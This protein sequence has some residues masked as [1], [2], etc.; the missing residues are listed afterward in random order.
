MAST[1]KKLTKTEIEMRWNA[2]IAFSKINS[3]IL[4]TASLS[5][6]VACVLAIGAL[7]ENLGDGV[8]IF[9]FLLF[10]FIVLFYRSLKTPEIIIDAY[11]TNLTR[12][13][14]EEISKTVRRREENTRLWLFSL[15]TFILCLPAI[16]IVTHSFLEFHGY[17][18]WCAW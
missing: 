6:L 11:A 13:E 5:S 15:W 9:S 17:K 18:V 12:S 4:P 1:S 7:A 14:L 16:Y 8:Y 2:I 3:V 10:P